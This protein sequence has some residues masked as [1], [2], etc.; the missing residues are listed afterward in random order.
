MFSKEIS[1]K[2][3]L[4]VMIKNIKEI[5][6]NFYSSLKHMRYRNGYYCMWCH[7]PGVVNTVKE[8]RLLRRVRL[9]RKRENISLN[10]RPWMII[11]RPTHVIRAIFSPGAVVSPT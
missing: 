5:V 8:R 1:Q 3:F 7:I 4:C 10:T 6:L 9:Y 11:P 2:C